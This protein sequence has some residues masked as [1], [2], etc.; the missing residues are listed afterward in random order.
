[1]HFMD[2]LPPLP[3]QVARAETTVVPPPRQPN[4]AERRLRALLDP[5]ERLI[6]WTRGWVSRDGHMHR[7]FAARTLDYAVISDSKLYLFSTGFFTRQPRRRVYAS[8][9]EHLQVSSTGTK[10]GHRMRILSPR[11]HQP[12]LLENRNT[13]HNVAF[14][15]ELVIRT[16]SPM[17][18]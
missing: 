7:V 2:P 8:E 13:E 16:R 5:G 17:A 6:T 4:R 18:P 1:M 10:R 14:A 12:I 3:K 15:L 11:R 9:F